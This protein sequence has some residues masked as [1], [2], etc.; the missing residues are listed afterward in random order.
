M[1]TPAIEGRIKGAL[2]IVLLPRA[3]KAVFRKPLGP[4]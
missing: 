2:I 1:K 4:G 3:F